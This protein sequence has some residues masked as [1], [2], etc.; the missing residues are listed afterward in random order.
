M[1]VR[2]ARPD[3]GRLTDDSYFVG[4]LTGSSPVVFDFVESGSVFVPFPPME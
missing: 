4:V 1:C 2:C 3:L